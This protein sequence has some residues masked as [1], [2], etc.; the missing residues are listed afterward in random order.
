M[1]KPIV[2][3]EHVCQGVSEEEDSVTK[4]MVRAVY[5]ID[6]DHQFRDQRRPPICYLKF[7]I[8]DGKDAMEQTICRNISK[9]P[10]EFLNEMG[11]CLADLKDPG[12]KEAKK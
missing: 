5:S 6:R 2:V 9:A 8:E 1:T 11:E 3:W 7:E 4:R 12:K 10:T